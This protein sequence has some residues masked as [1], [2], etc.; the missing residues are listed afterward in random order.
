MS[1]PLRRATT[2]VPMYDSYLDQ[3]LECTGQ[4]TL[5]LEGNLDFV[6]DTIQETTAPRTFTLRKVQ[7]QAGR[8]LLKKLPDYN[9][10]YNKTLGGRI[11]ICNADR[12]IVD[13]SENLNS[14]V[15]DYEAAKKQLETSLSEGDLFTLIEALKDQITKVE[16]Y[17]LILKGQ[18]AKRASINGVYLKLLK[19]KS[20]FYNQEETIRKFNGKLIILA[21]QIGKHLAIYGTKEPNNALFI[22]SYKNIFNRVKNL[23]KV[24][25]EDFENLKKIYEK[26]IARP[27]TTS[28]LK[29]SKDFFLNF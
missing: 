12:K 5:D 15:V 2:I 23:N 17:F 25:V 18:F 7:E 22:Y 16:N 19:E 27:I 6:T 10:R 24:F 1:F 3:L 20:T 13:R 8:F 4:V 21:N 9:G 28:T 26:H 11:Q 14:I 29:F